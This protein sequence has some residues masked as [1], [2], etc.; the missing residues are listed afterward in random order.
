MRLTIFRS[1]VSDSY[2]DVGRKTVKRSGRHRREAVH[3]NEVAANGDLVFE[4]RLDQFPQQMFDLVI[5]ALIEIDE[6]ALQLRMFDH[7]HASQ[8]PKGGLRDFD[9]LCAAA[10]GMTVSRHEPERRHTPVVRG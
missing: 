5:G 8:S 3:V 6:P 2:G 4:V 1:A 7:G 9:V 10:D